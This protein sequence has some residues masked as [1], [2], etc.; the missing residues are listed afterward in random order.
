L[1]IVGENNHSKTE[2]GL[3]SLNGQ[4]QG[5]KKIITPVILNSF[6]DLNTLDV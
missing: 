2:N 4:K 3:G 6:Q 1:K 5:S